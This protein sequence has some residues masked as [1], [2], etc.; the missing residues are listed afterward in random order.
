MQQVVKSYVRCCL[1][2]LHFNQQ[3]AGWALGFLSFKR[4]NISFIIYPVAPKPTC[5]DRNDMSMSH[6]CHFGDI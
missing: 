5:I 2:Y 1:S 6:A 3:I 4:T